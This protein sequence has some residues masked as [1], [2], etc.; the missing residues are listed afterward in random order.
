MQYWSS[1]ITPVRVLLQNKQAFPVF[2]ENITKI[3]ETL[4]AGTAVMSRNAF[5]IS[6]VQITAGAFM[7]S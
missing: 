7:V 4:I 2:R 6:Q 5:V 1:L 3:Y